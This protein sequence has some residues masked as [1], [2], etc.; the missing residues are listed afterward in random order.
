MNMQR[1]I[2]QCPIF[3]TLALNICPYFMFINKLIYKL[4]VW[5]FGK[6]TLQKREQADTLKSTINYNNQEKII[7][8]N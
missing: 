2:N 3:D 5:N 1:A 8:I 6:P 4:F 7:Q